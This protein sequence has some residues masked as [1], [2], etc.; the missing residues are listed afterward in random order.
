MI[1]FFV[2]LALAALLANGVWHLG[3]AYLTYYRF[4]D[5]V[6][7]FAQFNP[8]KSPAE[9]QRRILDL[10]SQYDV[11]VA[12]DDVSVRRDERNHTVISGSYT[13]PV[14]LLPGYRHGWVFSLDLDVTMISD[15][16]PSPR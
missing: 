14:D 5:A 3:S 15:A 2:K 12:T 9:V 7:E 16:V 13:Q 11:P 1:K 10:A 6:T 4:K 8:K